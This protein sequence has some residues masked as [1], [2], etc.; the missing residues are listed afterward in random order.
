MSKGH[1]NRVPSWLAL[2]LVGL[3]TAA[4][5]GCERKVE[6][7][8]AVDDTVAD[9]C[10]NCHNGQLDAM[11]G[12]WAHSVHASGASVDYTS[13]PAPN[14]CQRCHNQDGFVGWITTGTIPTTSTNA[15][16]IGC[17][18]CHNPHENGD[19]R[20]RTTAAVTMK[21]GAVFDVGRANLCVNCHQARETQGV[22]SD[23]YTITSS[24]TRF[25]PHHGPQGDLLI[26]S[27]GYEGLPGFT[28]ASTAHKDYIPGGGVAPNG[29]VGCH[30]NYAQT[31]E[32]YE[33]GGHSFN[34]RDEVG[35]S[36]AADCK[37]SGCHAD[38]GPLAF[39]N[40]TSGQPFDYKLTAGAQ[41]WDKDGALEGYQTEMQGMMDSLRTLLD[42][43][44]IL[45]PATDLA[46][47]G[48]YA[49]DLVGA[50]W[51]YKLMEEDRSKGVHNWRYC[52]ELMEASRDYVASLPTPP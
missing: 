16:A 42:V 26:A 3:C 45:N 5:T 13:R 51:N 10:F 17:F 36:L 7:T 43:Q 39:S 8:V 14:D 52:A 11:Q 40:P 31:H 19:M 30:M 21:T 25:G 41:D 23:P 29:C 20:L 18:A 49:G 12:E 4:M 33:V 15:K 9:Q 34:M 6:G 22:I 32:G 24:N 2:V 37:N 28:K 38:G 47:P 1:K 44:N 46:V 35:N 27:N 48:T 50:F